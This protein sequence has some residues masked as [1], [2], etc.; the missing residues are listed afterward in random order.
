MDAN[1]PDRLPE[2]AVEEQVERERWEI[3]EQL[4][5]W[6][7][8]P[9]LV[10]S[11]VW[12]VLVIIDFTT[13]LSP[14]LNMLLY[15]IWGIFIF[16]FALRFWTAPRKLAFLRTNWLTALS[17]FIPALRIGRIARLARIFRALRG[18]RLISLVGSVNRGMRVLRTTLRQN[19]FGYV[20]LL[21]LLIILVGAAGIF[22]FEGPLAPESIGSYGDALYWTSMVITSMGTD[23]WPRSA[24]GRL[25]ALLLATYGFAMF[26]YVTATLA[27][28]FIGQRSP[29][30]LSQPPASALSG[31]DTPDLQAEIRALRLEVGA[32]RQAL[33][34]GDD[35]GL[36]ERSP[37]I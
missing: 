3:L 14:F 13:G 23:Y 1:G 2:Q 12:L 32:L 36:E 27:T 31:E 30:K 17:L 11:L 9:V 16:D 7:E 20:L 22:A 28:F 37:E 35:P 34:R 29:E 21:T 33:A 15:F 10:L 24:E 26:G 19:G 6:L 18:A 25:L 8:G 5:D 4:E